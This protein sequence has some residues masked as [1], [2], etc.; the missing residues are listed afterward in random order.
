MPSRD[1]KHD[2]PVDPGEVVP[3]YYEIMSQ[4]GIRKGRRESGKV[5]DDL[6]GY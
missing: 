2:L 6:A 5:S 3:G 4:R 1:V